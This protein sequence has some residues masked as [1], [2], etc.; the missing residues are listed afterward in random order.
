MFL[1]SLAKIVSPFSAN[2]QLFAL[3]Y[4][5]PTAT[6]ML[7]N[8][9]SIDKEGVIHFHKIDADRCY[10]TFNSLHFK[11]CLN[12][13][14][15]SVRIDN[16]ET[17]IS[18]IDGLA[19]SKD[20][21]DFDKFKTLAQFAEKT[22]PNLIEK[23]DLANLTYTLSH[24]RNLLENKGLSI[25]LEHLQ[26]YSWQNKIYW[27]NSGG[28]HHFAAAQYIANKMEVS[29]NVIGKLQIDYFDSTAV[30][31]FNNCYDVFMIPV[32]FYHAIGSWDIELCKGL[33]SGDSFKKLT[34]LFVNLTIPFATVT[35][36][37]DQFKNISVLETG[38]KL[39]EIQLLVLSK[40]QTNPHI[41][42]QLH[43]RFKTL[44][45]E[46]SHQLNVQRDNKVLTAALKSTGIKV[47]L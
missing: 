3:C 34:D 4:D 28:S 35:M 36:R 10:S 11:D 6:V 20:K 43:L 12:D 42:K 26:I 38:I 41:L 30:A 24:E 1:K 25:D 27:S 31:N 15:Q 32:D 46:L 7:E 8:E 33:V 5:L 21:G 17:D 2:A 14:V 39:S 18:K 29:V 40:T 45:S 16:F 44:N 22:C 9:N 37:D 19:E 47:K 23:L 13:L